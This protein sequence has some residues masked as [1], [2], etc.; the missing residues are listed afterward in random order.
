MPKTARELPREVD[1]EGAHLLLTRDN[2]TYI[3]VREPDEHEEGRPAG[4]VNVPFAGDE[5]SFVARMQ[6]RFAPDAKLVV[7]C[8]SGR[9]SRRA[10]SALRTAG[11]TDV[12]DCRT[13]WDGS[14]GVF[15]ELREPGWKRMGLPTESGSP[16]RS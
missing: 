8:Q 14:R 7:G 5:V 10:V 15:G 11:F 2:Y 3:D 16:T 6:A 9:R 12:V 1:A 13:G 4:A